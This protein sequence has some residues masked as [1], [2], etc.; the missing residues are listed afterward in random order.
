MI[1]GVDREIGAAAAGSHH[2]PLRLNSNIL[3]VS[4]LPLC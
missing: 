2:R 1:P 4:N 3:L